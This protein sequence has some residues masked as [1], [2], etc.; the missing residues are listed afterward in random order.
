MAEFQKV[1]KQAKRMCGAY[2]C[3]KCP[4]GHVVGDICPI[5]VTQD[6][7]AV[8][9][10]RIVM[11]WAENN[12][13]PR[14]PSWIEWQGANFQMAERAICAAHFMDAGDAGCYVNGRC[15]KCREQPIPADIAEKLGIK[16][17]GGDTDA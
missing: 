9:I 15:D 5:A 2:D 14:Y 16:P 4:L 12:P 8:K 13:E 7:E 10:E 3:D 6:D 17:I 11:D 1:M